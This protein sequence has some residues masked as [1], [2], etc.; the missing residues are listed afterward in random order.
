MNIVVIYHA[1]CADGF[2]AAYAAWK[3]F[4]NKA[5]YIPMN[6]NRDMKELKEPTELYILDF[7]FS[8]DVLLGLEAAGHKILVLDHHK[9]A[10]ADLDGLPFA[11]FDMNKSGAVLAWEH[12]HPGTPLPGLLAMIQDRDLWKFELPYTKVVSAALSL[13][14]FDFEAWDKFANQIE[15]PEGFKEVL[16][17]GEAILLYQLDRA[18]AVA[19]KAANSIQSLGT[20]KVPV[21]NNTHL[22]SETLNKVLEM[23]P[24]IPFAASYFITDERKYVYSLRSVGDFDVS[25]VAKEYG[26]GGHKNAAGFTVDILL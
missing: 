11:V 21:F 20:W 22:I 26:G 4:G 10:A 8:K 15:D 7:S 25:A 3:K 12:F 6:Y 23:N 19:K 13:Q 5:K 18:N 2:G 17:V 16:K 9:T 24:D 1:S 14:G